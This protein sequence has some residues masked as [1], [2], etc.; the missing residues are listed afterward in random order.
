[1]PSSGKSTIGRLLAAHLGMKFIDLD[2]VIAKKEGM[3]I[4]DIFRIKG[5]SYFRES[6]RKHLLSLIQENSVFILATG[7]G[8]PCFF[9]NMEIMNK[10]AITIYLNISVEDLFKKLSKKGTSHRPL[11]QN[12]SDDEL[13]QEL[14]SKFK[15]RE[16]YYNAA[17]IC[18]S[19]HFSSVTERVNAVIDAIVALEK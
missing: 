1:M 17:Q 2:E 16:I 15:A 7:G 6:E 18:L 9:D 3:S 19:Q 11:L 8:T 13:Y 12:M 14:K 5:E 10:Y 4:S